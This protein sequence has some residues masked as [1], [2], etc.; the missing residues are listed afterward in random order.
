MILPADSLMV[1]TY[2]RT[3]G[4]LTSLQ[5]AEAFRDGG[6][7]WKESIGPDSDYHDRRISIPARL[8]SAVMQDVAMPM[9]DMV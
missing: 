3:H 4:V 5:K 9:K 7:H 2:N 6:C 8:H 1:D